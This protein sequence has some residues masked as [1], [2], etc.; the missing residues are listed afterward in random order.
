MNMRKRE[1]IQNH[2]CEDDLA[3]KLKVVLQE[4]SDVDEGKK[5]SDRGYTKSDHSP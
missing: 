5:R 1:K 4:L 2:V 3:D